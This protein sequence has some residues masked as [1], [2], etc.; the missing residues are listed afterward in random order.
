MS[1]IGRSAKAMTSRPGKAFDGASFGVGM[2][3]AFSKS[4]RR[5]S[6]STGPSHARISRRS[7]R[8]SSSRTA[9]SNG[10]PNSETIEP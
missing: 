6:A 3:S 1:S 10:A 2:L 9:I 4:S 5:A 8:R 7:C